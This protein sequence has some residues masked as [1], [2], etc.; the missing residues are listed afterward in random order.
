MYVAGHARVVTLCVCFVIY[1]YRV[2]RICKYD[3]YSDSAVNHDSPCAL[4]K[5]MQV[6]YSMYK[7]V[8]VTITYIYIYIYVA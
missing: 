3:V 2:V 1:L 6:L 4:L 8:A 5:D 7:A